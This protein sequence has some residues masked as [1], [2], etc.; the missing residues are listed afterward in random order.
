MGLSSHRA[1]ESERDEWGRSRS[2]AWMAAYGDDYD[3]G[4]FEVL[5]ATASILESFE[6]EY[7]LNYGSALDASRSGR[8]HTGETDADI[9]VWVEDFTRIQEVLKAHLPSKMQLISWPNRRDGD[10]TAT[11]REFYVVMVGARFA[12]SGLSRLDINPY[13][14]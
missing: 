10:E 12:S 5:N 8:I 4:I 1:L 13:L 3:P 14:R 11:E 2:Q 9:G 7:F 6:I